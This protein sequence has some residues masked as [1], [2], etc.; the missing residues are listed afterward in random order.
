MNFTARLDFWSHHQKWQH[1]GRKICL[2]TAQGVYRPILAHIGSSWMHPW[3]PIAPRY[4]HPV[5]YAG[6]LCWLYSDKIRGGTEQ[7]CYRVKDLQRTVS[8]WFNR[9]RPVLVKEGFHSPSLR[10]CRGVV[11]GW[12]DAGASQVSRMGGRRGGQPQKHQEKMPA[13]T[14]EAHGNVNM[15]MAKLALHVDHNSELTGLNS[16]LPFIWPGFLHPC[17]YFAHGNGGNPAPNFGEEES[18][19]PMA[20]GTASAAVSKLM[21]EM[22]ELIKQNVA[23]EGLLLC[24]GWSAFLNSTNSGSFRNALA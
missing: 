5:N 20:G 23:G 21:L 4:L 24:S 7:H 19:S 10:C 13:N 22:W 2:P 8:S 11:V 9:Q 1:I 17:R 6:F 12:G 16:Y 14:W 18:V 3:D 15:D